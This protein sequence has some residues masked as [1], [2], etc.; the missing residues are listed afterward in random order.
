MERRKFLIGLGSVAAGGAAAMGTGA[1]TSVEADR[2]LSI[3]TAGDANAFLSFKRATDPDGNVYPNAEEYVHGDLNGET[4]S[5][6]FTQSNDTAGSASG[7]NQNAKTIFDNLFDITNNGSQDVVLTVQSDLIASQGGFLG[8]YA[9]NS[10]EEND[11]DGTG[12]S[13]PDDGNN[14]DTSYWGAVEIP[15]GQTLSNVGIYIPKGHSTKDL[16]GGT[17]TFIA[18]RTGG[19]KD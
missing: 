14:T 10:Q 12:L 15:V 2:T 3:D 18:E 4:L 11:T 19:N 9:E 16:N 8:I 6:D 7:I 17:L 1:F 5:L 13:Y